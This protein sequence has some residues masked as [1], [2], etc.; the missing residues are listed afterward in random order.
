MTVLASTEP[1]AVWQPTQSIVPTDV[2]VCTV[3]I[4]SEWQFAHVAVALPTVSAVVVAAMVCVAS[5]PVAWFGSCG[6]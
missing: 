5:V 6:V 1:S 2:D 3:F 4:L